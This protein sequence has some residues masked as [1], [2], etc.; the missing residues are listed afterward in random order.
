M[1]TV[2]V[3]EIIKSGGPDRYAKTKGVDARTVQI[4]GLI[5]MSKSEVLRMLKQ[6]TK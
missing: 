1:K 6:E 4:G 3:S 2:S 5:P